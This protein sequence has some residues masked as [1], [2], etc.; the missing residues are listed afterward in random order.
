MED[1]KYSERMVLD[2]L[3]GFNEDEMVY[4][5]N[6]INLDNYMDNCY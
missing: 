5:L 1:I 6:G 2:E 4:W 3:S